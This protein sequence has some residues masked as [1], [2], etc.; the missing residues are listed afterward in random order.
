M[1]Q[2]TTDVVVKGALD[3]LAARQRAYVNNV[4]NVDTPGF[5]PSDVP[6]EAQLR[7]VRDEMAGQPQDVEHA[8]SLDLSTVI[9]P[10][11]ANRADGN[12]VQIDTQVTRLEENSM[13]YEALA[14]AVHNRNNILLSAITEGRK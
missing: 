4:A 9:D 2:T 3:G 11:G 8:P 14:Q 13:T 7:K 10:Q 1:L 6:F 5:K 12:D